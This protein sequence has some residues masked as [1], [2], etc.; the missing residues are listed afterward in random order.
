MVVSKITCIFAADKVRNN[1]QI[2]TARELRANQRKYFDLAEK[3]TILVSRRKARPIVISVADDD[4]ILTKDE[5]ESI[6]KGLDDIK[7]GRVYKM[8]DNET[9][10]D[11]I[12]RTEHV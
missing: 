6:K 7:E 3:E 2:I 5:L 12:K 4:D 9:L 8:K 1:M 10:E 11:F